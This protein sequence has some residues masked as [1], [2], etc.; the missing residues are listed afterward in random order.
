MINL[1]ISLKNYKDILG[2]ETKEGRVRK[3]DADMIMKETWWNDI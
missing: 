3:H 2:G 1:S